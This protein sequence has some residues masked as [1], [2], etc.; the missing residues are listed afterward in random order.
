MSNNSEKNFTG[1]TL[2]TADLALLQTFFLFF[3]DTNKGNLYCKNRTKSPAANL[4][5]SPLAMESSFCFAPHYINKVTDNK[6]Q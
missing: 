5:R 6:L 1:D 3:F 2:I 4:Q